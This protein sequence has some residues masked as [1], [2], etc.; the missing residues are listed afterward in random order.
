[1]V[2]IQ[3]F[4]T[5]SA[6]LDILAILGICLKIYDGAYIQVGYMPATMSS[7]GGNFVQGILLK[8]SKNEYK[9]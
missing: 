1:M 8:H 5:F 7:L 3:Y 4:F 6:K 2:I 9:L